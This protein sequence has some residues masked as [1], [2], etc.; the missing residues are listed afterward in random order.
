MLVGTLLRRWQ[1]EQMYSALPS[2]YGAIDTVNTV[3][4]HID[5]D[6]DTD[7]KTEHELVQKRRRVGHAYSTRCVYWIVYEVTTH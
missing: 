5:S 7:D 3:L 4:T 1:H 2:A 6:N